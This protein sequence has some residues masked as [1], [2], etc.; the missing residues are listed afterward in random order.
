M[1]LR[2]ANVIRWTLYVL[3]AGLTFIGFADDDAPI[4]AVVG[5]CGI[6]LGRAVKYVVQGE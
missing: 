4:V 1:F 3:G 5:I 6:V 2:L